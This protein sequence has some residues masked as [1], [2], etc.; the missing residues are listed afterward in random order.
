MIVAFSVSP[1]GVGEDVGEDLA[2]AVRVVR[3]SGPPTAPTPVGGARGAG[4]VRSPWP[5]GPSG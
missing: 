2:D 4:G 1:L 5:P 3:E